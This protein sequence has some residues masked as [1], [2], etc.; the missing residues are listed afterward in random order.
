ML[1]GYSY[2]LIPLSRAALDD[3]MTRRDFS[4]INITIPYKQDVMP[5]C[6]ELDPVARE[7]ESVNTIIRTGDR[8]KGYNTDYYGFCA[9]LRRAGIALDGKTVMILG[10]GGTALTARYAASVLGASDILMISRGG[11]LNYSNLSECAGAQIIIN[12]TPV[13]MYPDYDGCLISL[14][15]F[16]H[17][18][19]VVDVIYNPLRTKL[20]L[21]AR[22]MGI[23]Y[24]NGL[25]MLVY[26]AKRA[27]ELFTGED[28]ADEKAE[29][30]L[31]VLTAEQ[32]SI[33]LIGMPSCGKSA[34]GKCLAQRLGVE[35][36]DTDAE[37]ERNCSMGIPEIF[38]SRGEE[39]FRE[40]EAKVIAELAGGGRRV[41]ATGGGAVENPANRCNISRNS[42]VFY[43]RRALSALSGTNRPLSSGPEA[44]RGLYE[45]RA[46]LYEKC[47]DFTVDNDKTVDDAVENIIRLL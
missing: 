5:Y 13:G 6:A 26:Q 33:V 9:M 45:R 14:S 4:G 3:F 12:T 23:P 24:A 8:L 29:H 40:A 15:D 21:S 17:C 41:I 38:A 27:A 37:I 7:I 44:I 36:T 18:G 25:P 47:A 20:L 11:R 10:G 46:P 35:F 34:I 39:Y 32:Q 42:A 2:S 22:E 19:G 31:S 43:I 16:P 30:I 28:I 1:G